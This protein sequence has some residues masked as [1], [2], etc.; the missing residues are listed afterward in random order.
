MPEALEYY[1]NMNEDFDML[2]M[3]EGSESGDDENSSDD[4]DGGK[5]KKKG[6][7]SGDDAGNAGAGADGQ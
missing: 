5:K 1:L 3:G 4:D 6:K 2:D 7:K